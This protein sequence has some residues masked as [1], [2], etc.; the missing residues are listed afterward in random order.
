M[1]VGYIFFMFVYFINDI[2]VVIMI[3][4]EGIFWCELG[5]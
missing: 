2:D 3:V 1:W 4:N 5:S